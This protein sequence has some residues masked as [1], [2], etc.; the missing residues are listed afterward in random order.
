VC[1]REVSRQRQLKWRS[2]VRA[3]QSMKCEPLIKFDISDDI[4]CVLLPN[5]KWDLHSLYVCV[6]VWFDLIRGWNELGPRYPADKECVG[7]CVCACVCEC[8]C[9]CVKRLLA[10]IRGLAGN[11]KLL[12]LKWQVDSVS[13]WFCVVP[14]PSPSFCFCLDPLPSSN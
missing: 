11:W 7:V 14:P 6:C 5:Y 2:R 4:F 8:V 1:E 10:L 13:Q 12:V 3:S 9:V